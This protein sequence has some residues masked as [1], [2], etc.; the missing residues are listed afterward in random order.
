[1]RNVNRRQ[2]LKLLGATSITSAVGFPGYLYAKP[3]ARVVVVGGG[4]G[5]ATAAGYLKHFDPG[6]EVTL[7][8]PQ[9]KFVTCPFSNAVLAGIHD[10]KFITQTYDGLRTARGIKIVQD[11]VAT[12]DAARKEVQLKSGKSLQYDRLVVSPGISFRWNEIE[13]HN[14]AA[15]EIMPHAWQAGAQTILL[16]KQIEAMPNGGVVIIAVPRTPFRAPPAPYERA[17]LI[18]YYLKANKPNSKV[19]IVDANDSFS[20]QDLFTEAWEKLYPGMIEWVKGSDAGSIVR[21]D[22]R[23]MKIFTKTGQS[24]KGD[25]V[26]LIPGQKAGGI[27][28]S[29]GLVDAKGWSPVNQRTFESKLSKGIYVI[30]DAAIAGDMPKTGHSANSQAKV[31]AAAIVSELGGTKMPDPVYSTSIYS[32]LSP[33]YAISLAAVYRIKNGRIT[34]VSS[35]ES[36][37]KASKKTRLKEAK[38][39]SG[40]YKSITSDTFAKQNNNSH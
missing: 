22:A 11:T 27:V 7:V 31:C 40:W 26:N 35:G 33:K 21:V 17:S 24:F 10:M 37:L 20:K 30:G 13:G 9:P 1:M 8:E 25:V 4:F 38:F 28:V 34:T 32:L 36:A 23:G 16:R 39:A 29:A 14:E 2:V 5:G 18:A 15:A 19:L 6:I 3:T 12:I